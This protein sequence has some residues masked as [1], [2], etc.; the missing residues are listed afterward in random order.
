VILLLPEVR[1]RLIDVPSP[2]KKLCQLLRLKK[3]HGEI[4]AK[5]AI[6][7]GT[8]Q[9]VRHFTRDSRLEE[10]DVPAGLLYTHNLK[11]AIRLTNTVATMAPKRHIVFDRAFERYAVIIKWIGAERSA[12]KSTLLRAEEVE[13]PPKPKNRTLRQTQMHS[14]TGTLMRNRSAGKHPR[15]ERDPLMEI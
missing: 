4:V 9:L 15:E 3:W 5:I 10:L 1:P 2:N 12:T 6:S 7:V 8:G 11:M 13:V 14:Q